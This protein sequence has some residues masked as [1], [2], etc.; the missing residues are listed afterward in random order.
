MSTSKR[1][2]QP[3]EKSTYEVPD[4]NMES[5]EEEQPRLS[6]GE[7]L[8]RLDVMT[9]RILQ[10]EKNKNELTGTLQAAHERIEQLGAR[11][12]AQAEASQR[13]PPPPVQMVQGKEPGQIIKPPK[14]EPFDGTSTK[15]RLF[16][17]QCRAYF[18][19]CPIT[20]AGDT[21]RGIRF[22][23][24][25]QQSEEV[26]C[27][28]SNYSEFERTQEKAFG[29]VDEKTKAELQIKDLRQKGSA[30]SYGNTLIQLASK[31]NWGQEALMA[32]LFN[33]LRKEVQEELF[34]LE[35]PDHLV[36][37]IVI[38]VKIEDRQYAWGTRN[39]KTKQDNRPRYPANASASRNA[40]TLYGTESGLME[41][42]NV[43]QQRDRSHIKCYN[44]GET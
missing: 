4:D 18:K 8:R 31:L 28:Y 12:P 25:E 13:A 6:Q 20:L 44:C 32:K 23:T 29:V 35:R 39:I 22:L 19:F 38:A 40:N 1:P 33:G 3:V 7:V 34:K 24:P 42:G 10:L 16:M 2:E 30:S 14:L 9:K 36:N 11:R 5:D 17:A 37:Y 41:L 21:S 43:Q 26:R 27:V 15:L